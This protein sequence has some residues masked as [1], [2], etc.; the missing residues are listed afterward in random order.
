M[1][2]CL[3]RC[4]GLNEYERQNDVQVVM[5][6]MMKTFESDGVVLA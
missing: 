1:W 3:E 6:V 4:C 2:Q 5:T